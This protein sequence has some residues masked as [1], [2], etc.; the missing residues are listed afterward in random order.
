MTVSLTVSDLFTPAPSGVGPFGNVPAV[1]A[2]G[3]WFGISLQIAATVQLPTTSWQAGAPERTILAIG[4]VNFASSD[5]DISI[6]AQGGF[7]QS[8]AS[9]SVTYTSTNGTPITVLV[10]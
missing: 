1:P 3:T 8:A 9:G 6:M 7:L 10:T 4:S 5:V 2:S